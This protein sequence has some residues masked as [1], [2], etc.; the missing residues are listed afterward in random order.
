MTMKFLRGVM[1]KIEKLNR[2]LYYVSSLAIVL[3]AF[4]LTYEVI[5]RYVLRIPTIW[6]IETSVYLTIMATYLG[7]AYG[8]KDGAHIN[9]DLITRLLPKKFTE[10]LSLVTSTIAFVFCLLVAWKGWGMWWEATAKGWHS[11]SLW[12]PPLTIPYFFLPL[13]M[14]LLSLQY[15]M[16][17]SEIIERRGGKSHGS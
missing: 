11:E 10:K 5:V 8:L 3:S 15:V 4:I 13:G 14:T 7:A 17:I 2:T 12:G 6:E 16:L 1:Q 9:I